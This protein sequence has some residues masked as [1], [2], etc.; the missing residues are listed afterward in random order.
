ME[1]LTPA[2]AEELYNLKV[3]ES[4][5]IEKVLLAEMDRMLTAGF[6]E[7]KD[8]QCLTNIRRSAIGKLS[9]SY[10]IGKLEAVNVRN[11]YSNLG[12]HFRSYTSGEYIS[13]KKFE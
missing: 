12:F 6:A 1:Y 9:V 8:S 4:N 13:F 3:E 2:K 7:G 10:S 11:H 5:V